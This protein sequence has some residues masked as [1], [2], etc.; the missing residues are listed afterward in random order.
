MI[1]SA[2]TESKAPVLLVSFA[3]SDERAQVIVP[4]VR[5]ETVFTGVGKAAAA[6]VITENIL[7]HRPAA[8]LNVG[9]AG[10][11][12]MHIGDILPTTRFVDR[13]L[14]D[15]RLEGLSVEIDNK[16]LFP[17]LPPA[18][19]DGKVSLADFSVSTGDQFVT[20]SEDIAALR[21]EAIDMEAFALALACRRQDIPFLSIKYI[22]DIVGQNSVASWEEKL[23]DARRH[24]SEYF[25][26]PDVQQILTTIVKG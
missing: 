6:A 10:S 7:R 26:R 19:I 15:L 2:H 3:L 20:S 1:P 22:T 18:I 4:G 25:A 23:S 17:H 13:D 21:E 9:S 8:V 16:H 11:T 5:I 24:L 14:Y 12:H